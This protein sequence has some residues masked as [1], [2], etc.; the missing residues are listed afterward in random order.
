MARILRSLCNAAPLTVSIIL[1]PGCGTNAESKG[2][3]RGDGDTGDGDGDGS[4]GG[5]NATGTGGA[6]GDGDDG[7]GG[8]SV[9]ASAQFFNFE[10]GE[11]DPRFPDMPLALST[12]ELLPHVT[13]AVT[14]PVGT[15]SVGFDYGGNVRV[16]R[17]A[18]FLLTEEAF[19][20]APGS[21]S[22]TVSFFT[23]AD[24]SGAPTGTQVFAL[25]VTSAGTDIT[26]GDGQHSE[27]R[28]WVGADG[29]YNE[30]AGVFAFMVLLPD[31]YDP[32][33]KYPVMTYLH[34]GDPNYRGIDNNGLPLTTSPIF[35]GPRA[36]HTSQTRHDFPAIVVIPQLIAAET[37]ND[38]TNEWAT[39]T[40]G[41]INNGT[42]DYEPGPNPSVSAGHLFKALDDM[43]AG[44]FTVKG[45][46]EQDVPVTVDPGR[47]Y[48]GGHSM[49]GFGT[50]DVLMR[51]PAFFA[52]GVPMAGYQDH[53]TAPSLVDT[54]IWAF[55]HEIDS[56]N[57]FHSDTML[58]LIQ[59]AGGTKMKLT[60]LTFDTGGAGD[61]AHFR[62]P[63]AVWIDEPEIFN[64]LFSQARPRE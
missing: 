60:K 46:N 64:W 61:Q 38:I 37:I 17:A 45:A 12:V 5:G 30:T 8:V 41:S 34:H 59:A 35:T 19:D 6:S 22:I 36:I 1:L 43:V 56:Y 2:A 9:E 14:P 47:I 3:S 58:S 15:I 32:A 20:F 53:E 50:W 24:G 27:H 26:P 4:T 10:T 62:T 16:D 7:T 39:F 57:P 33:V 40:P 54:P 52:A 13:I 29:S 44:T 63:D 55:H 25:E 49:G 18:P 11:A 31:G 51:R 23:T 42:G 48:I 28:L 21:H